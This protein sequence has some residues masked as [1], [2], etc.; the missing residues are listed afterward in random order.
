MNGS[1]CVVDESRGCCVHQALGFR[2][3][4]RLACALV[5]ILLLIVPRLLLAQS[6]EH[7]QTSKAEKSAF[8]TGPEVGQKIPYFHALDQSGKLQDFNSVRGPKGAMI[9]F[10]RSAD[11]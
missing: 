8:A 7:Q 10:L 4:E 3:V 5:V 9:V 6:S 2:S 11:W 1:K